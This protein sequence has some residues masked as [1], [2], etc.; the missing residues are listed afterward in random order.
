MSLRGL[1]ARTL[2]KLPEI[3]LLKLSGGEPYKIGERTLDPQLQFLMHQGRNNPPFSELGAVK[4][5]AAANEAISMIAAKPEPGVVISDSTIPGADDYQIQIGIYRPEIQ[6]MKAPLMV[7]YHQ[8]GGV[9]GNL[10]WP[11]VICSMISKIACCPVVSVDYRLAPE[12]K[13]PAGLDDCIAAYEWG[14]RNAES[15]GAP[16]GIAAIGGDSMGGNFAA[17]IAQEMKRLQKPA[18]KLQLLIYPATDIQGEYRSRETHGQ[19]FTLTSELMDWF[20][21][22]YLP[23]GTDLNDLRISPARET[24]LTG[25]PPAIVVTAG[26]D[27]LVDEGDAYAA[28][29]SDAGNDVIHQRYDTMAHGFTAFTAAS[30]A[31]DAAC[32][33]IAEMVLTVYKRHSE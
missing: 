25:L 7:Y 28:L 19:T 18:P 20:M 10:D 17:I 9:I 30:M 3:W 4:A 6:H 16:S 32:R 24:S 1:I 5:R 13:F 21:G 8:G 14:L 26:F 27:P 12:H 15:L 29:L 33:E 31:A 22:Q 11:N 23:D 2:L